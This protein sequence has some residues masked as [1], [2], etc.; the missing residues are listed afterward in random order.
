[1]LFSVPGIAALIVR[2]LVAR[3]QVK[4]R[5]FAAGMLYMVNSFN[6][7]QMRFA[8]AARR[9]APYRQPGALA[10]AC[11]STTTG[12]GNQCQR[13]STPL[14]SAVEA[15]HPDRS[16]RADPGL[17]RGGLAAQGHQPAGDQ[18]VAGPRQH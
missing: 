13:P 18:I 16:P 7:D 11:F 15:L 3:R 10:A 6:S 8:Y 9:L 14:R 17:R 5:N 12:A 4:P 2:I 1:M